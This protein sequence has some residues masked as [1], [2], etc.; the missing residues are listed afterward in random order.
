MIVKL[1]EE[2][3]ANLVIVRAGQSG[4]LGHCFSDKESYRV[5]LNV[6]CEVGPSSTRIFFNKA[7]DPEFIHP[8]ISFQLE[9]IGVEPYLTPWAT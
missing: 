1:V 9:F 4:V 3:P 8:R 5:N 7:N 2:L 6:W